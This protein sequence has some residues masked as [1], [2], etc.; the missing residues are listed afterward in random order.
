M[1]EGKEMIYNLP[2][3][4]KANSQDTC[5]HRWT[6]RQIRVKVID[7]PSPTS[8]VIF[9]ILRMNLYLC[10]QNNIFSLEI[11]KKRHTQ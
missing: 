5:S 7:L 2:V 11:L 8:V 6:K 1:T 3:Q 9:T 10:Q 4:I